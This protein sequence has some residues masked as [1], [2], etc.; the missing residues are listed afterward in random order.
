MRRFLPWGDL[1]MMRKQLM[2]LKRLAETIAP[3]IPTRNH[4]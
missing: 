1:V 3:T 2:N 4:R